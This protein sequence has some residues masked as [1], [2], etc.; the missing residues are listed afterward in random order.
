MAEASSAADAARCSQ[1]LKDHKRE[2][3]LHA[4]LTQEVGKQQTQGKLDLES[5]ERKMAEKAVGGS[6]AQL[7]ARL[8]S[9]I[10]QN[11]LALVK[12]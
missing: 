12:K 8:R 3:E 7:A 11:N 9:A 2:M 10:R 1:L 5:I 6:E 4:E